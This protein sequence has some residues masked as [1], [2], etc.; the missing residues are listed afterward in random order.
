MITTVVIL[1][2]YDIKK[3]IK[4]V[5]DDEGNKTIIENIYVLERKFGG[6]SFIAY[7][8]IKKWK[9]LKIFKNL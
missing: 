4:I 6:K 1:N 8:T 5:D 2:Y 9:I 7:E 3:V